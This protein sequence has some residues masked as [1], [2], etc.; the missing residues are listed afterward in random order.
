VV[1][2]IG[3]PEQ[4]TAIDDVARAL[5]TARRLV[6]RGGKIVVLSRAEGEPGPALNRLI[7]ADDPRVGPNVLRGHA[8]DPDYPAARAI[9]KALA[10]ADV[11][12]LSG[13]APNTVEDLSMIPLD[14]AEEARR[15]AA[16]SRS[17]LVVSHADL[18]R[19]VVADE[20]D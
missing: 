11:Y 8:S 16:T 12:L 18:T 7:A 10:W 15:L 14:R 5:D 6:Q 9:A 3:R 1:A 19:G 13:L 17:C 4:P 20:A 2:G